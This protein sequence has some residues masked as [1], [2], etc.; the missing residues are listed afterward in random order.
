MSQQT[1]SINVEK[2]EELQEFRIMGLKI[3][4][5]MIL[6]VIVIGSSYMGFLPGGMAG[7]IPYMLV[8]GAIFNLIGENTPIV[9]DY[10]GGGS[11]VILF[12]SAALVM[13]NL[14]PESIPVQAKTFITSGGFIDLTLSALIIGSVFGMNRNI[15][16]KAIVLYLPCIAGGLIVA[17]LFAGLVGAATGFGFKEAILYVAIPIMGGGT[18]A[19]AVP[20]S[21]MYAGILGKDPGEMLSVMTPAV[22]MGNAVAIIIAGFLNKIGKS[23][24]SL[25]GEG[26]LIRSK[27]IDM[28]SEPEEVEE[29][30]IDLS[31]ISIGI[32][33]AVV[34]LI[35]GKFIQKTFF[36]DIHAYAWM[37]L[38][39]VIVK[40]A[41]IMPKDIEEATH[42]FF[43]LIVQNFTKM[44]L[45][46][47]GLALIRLDAV[48]A[49][50]SIEYLLLVVVTVLGSVIGA[51]L[52]GHIVGFFFVESS[53]TAGLCMANMGGSGDLA[54][55]G[56]AD[57]MS[58]MPF[59]AVSSRLGGSIVL[60]LSGVLLKLFV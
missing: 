54:T 37:V 24:P 19:G 50:F 9:K 38:A 53:I 23:K 31:T 22:A 55:L 49:A 11:M 57:R 60:I 34:F 48:V 12:G 3:H 2:T 5:F 18:S 32:A 59:A 42:L 30:K 8:L 7:I 41:G 40:I 47:L 27:N 46:S 25:S 4:Y 52:V 14:V 36:P 35:I 39:A 13:F 1:N 6:A 51:G 16:K 33:Y 26:K 17:F 10:L 45:V 44:I 21:Q 43:S 56:A 20:L 58:L 15:L 29:K 28:S